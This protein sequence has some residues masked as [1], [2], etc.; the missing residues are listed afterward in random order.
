MKKILARILGIT[1]VLVVAI[2]VVHSYAESEISLMSLSGK[3]TTGGAVTG[4]GKFPLN[5]SGS[6]GIKD[7]LVITST[8]ATS[9][10]SIYIRIEKPDG[11]YYNNTIS[12]EPNSQESFTVYY[13]PNGTYN[14]HY[15]VFGSTILTVEFNP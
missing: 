14:I 4:S 8:K 12:V 6:S 13:A 7:V 5:V 10:A 15:T 9:D 3:A 1:L 11:T 2:G